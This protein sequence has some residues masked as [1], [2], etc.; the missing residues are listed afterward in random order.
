MV[1][2]KSKI[3]VVC[4]AGP[5]IHLD[6][7]DC[8]GLLTDFQEILISD[9][10]WKEIKRYRPLDL[11]RSDLSFTLSPVKYPISEILLTIC[12][13]FSLDA[14]ETE[15]LAIME[16]NPN[17]VFLTD[18]ASARLVAKQMGFKV[19]GTIGI[20]VRS[21]RRGQ[22]KPE[23]VISIIKKIPIKSTLHIKPSLIEE[24]IFRIK[25]E[26]KI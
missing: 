19:H 3:R 21:I 24:V 26:F 23:E 16:N 2:I 6:E 17:T 1:M 18:D 11:K 12:R 15:A 20:L 13:I 10:I 4:D 9:T 7:L 25:K 5:I 14:G 8:L 22:M